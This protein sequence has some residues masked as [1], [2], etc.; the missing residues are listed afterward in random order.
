MNIDLDKINAFLS[1][2]VKIINDDLDRQK[3]D[4]TKKQEI[5]I[6]NG[7]IKRAFLNTY[8]SDIANLLNDSIDKQ[9]NDAQIYTCV[10]SVFYVLLHARTSEKIFIEFGINLYDDDESITAKNLQTMIREKNDASWYN[11]YNQIVNN[12]FKED[13]IIKLGFAIDGHFIFYDLTEKGRSAV[14]GYVTEHYQL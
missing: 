7:S 4:L 10:S 5:N 13:P 14:R 11:D 1:D 8:G 2:E 6:S 9:H 3:K 12:N